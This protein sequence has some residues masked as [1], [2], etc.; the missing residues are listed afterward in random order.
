MLVFKEAASDIFVQIRICPD[1]VELTFFL[2]DIYDVRRVIF[3]MPIREIFQYE[4]F[5]DSSLASQNKNLLSSE[6]SILSA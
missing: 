2:I 6:P 4:A 5:S 1:M 3:R